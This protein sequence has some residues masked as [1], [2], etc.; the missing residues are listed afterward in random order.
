MD[1]TPGSG[2]VARLLG[3]QPA[4]ALRDAAVAWAREFGDDL[5]RAWD[6]CPRGSWLHTLACT[7]GVA[8]QLTIA[9]AVAC[10]RAVSA[11]T[12]HE[13]ALIALGPRA[14][15]G[16][17]QRSGPD[18]AQ[19]AERIV[20]WLDRID[21]WTRGQASDQSCAEVVAGALQLANRYGALAMQTGDRARLRLSHI[22]LLFRALARTA[23]G[24]PW[25]N[26][27]GHRVQI[28]PSAVHL[29]IGAAEHA[30]AADAPD[31][32]MRARALVGQDID[33][34][35]AAVVREIIDRDA[36]EAC[37][38]LPPPPAP[39]PP[40]EPCYVELHIDDAQSWTALAELWTAMAEAADS[41]SDL[42]PDDP[43]WRERA[44]ALGL[45]PS[46]LVDIVDDIT[47]C[48]YGLG[49]ARRVSEDAGRLEVYPWSYPYGGLAALDRL[50]ELFGLPV[51][52]RENGTGRRLSTDRRR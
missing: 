34:A 51:C 25:A 10:V 18:V 22:S 9:A 8:D 41:K 45:S 35:L 50:A 14:Q 17:D 44:R 46:T 39:E 24:M 42:R 6:A 2:G 27:F 21:R 40:P 38:P 13:D 11:H 12:L 37:T 5:M 7:A 16:R 33:F 3:T 26:E 52:A 29:S 49:Q 43:Q 15:F 36:I 23:E 47:N 28:W 48:E 19:V 1:E 4:G 32:N 20:D 30:A 31:S